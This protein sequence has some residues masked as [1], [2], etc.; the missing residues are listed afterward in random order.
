[1]RVSKDDKTEGRA[2]SRPSLLVILSRDAQHR[3]S[4]GGREL[5]ERF[6]KKSESAKARV[7]STAFVRPH[8]ALGM[9]KLPRCR[10]SLT[11]CARN[12]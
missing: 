6:V 8:L 2:Q 1:V 4:K 9:K 10:L 7:L 5:V 3:V 11:L 12:P